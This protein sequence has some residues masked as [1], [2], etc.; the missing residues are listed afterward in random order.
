MYLF[1][2]TVDC[3]AL[4]TNNRAAVPSVLDT[5]HEAHNNL[6][7]DVIGIYSPSAHGGLSRGPWGTCFVDWRSTFMSYGK[8]E[9]RIT[10]RPSF[11]F[12]EAEL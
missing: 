9:H 10:C 6:R 11:I 2:S 8:V 4:V 5:M 12:M 7:S 3:N 1:L